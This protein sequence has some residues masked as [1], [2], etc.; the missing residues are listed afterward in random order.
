[1][2][3]FHKSI[4]AIPPSVKE[5]FPNLIG[6]AVSSGKKR[7]SYSLPPKGNA[8]KMECTLILLRDCLR[9]S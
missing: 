7:R 3:H 9:P 4:F 8:E 2:I 6:Q 1:M 5:R